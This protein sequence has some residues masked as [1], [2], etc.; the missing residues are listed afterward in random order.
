MLTVVTLLVLTVLYLLAKLHRPE[1]DR[2]IRHFTRPTTTTFIPHAVQKEQ[3]DRPA[4]RSQERHNERYRSRRFK[5]GRQQTQDNP[6]RRHHELNERRVLE[7]ARRVLERPR[8]DQESWHGDL[9]FH[10]HPPPN[11][12]RPPPNSPSAVPVLDPANYVERTPTNPGR[13]RIQEDG[14]SPI[15]SPRAANNFDWWPSFAE[16]AASAE[17]DRLRRKAEAEVQRLLDGEDTSP[18]A[19]DPLGTPIPQL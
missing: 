12:Q 8:Q 11:L 5:L 6:E 14:L 17:D 2:A 1:I 19:S 9:R 18:T 3:H 16:E 15:E 10:V 13:P 4:E 7:G